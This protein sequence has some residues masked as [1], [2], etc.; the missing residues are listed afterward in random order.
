VGQSAVSPNKAIAV[1][2]EADALSMRAD[3]LSYREIGGQLGVTE[4]GAWK[5]VQRAYKRSLTINDAE[6][7]FQRRLDLRRCDIAITALMPAVQSGKTRSV[8]VLMA[9]LKRRAD[10]LGLDAPTKLAPTDPS[11]ERPYGGLSDSELVGNL[12]A[13]FDRARARAGG[14]TGPGGVGPV[15]LKG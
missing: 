9:V 14:E 4:A 8:E 13:I 12:A 1:Q 11:G 6:A 10:L 7:D 2:R 15:E 5:M 3:G